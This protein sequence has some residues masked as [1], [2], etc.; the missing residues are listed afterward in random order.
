[1]GKQL[2]RNISYEASL[3]YD[4]TEE[5]LEW[6]F[7]RSN[8]SILY[9]EPKWIKELPKYQRKYIIFLLKEEKK[10]TPELIQKMV[11]TTKL[12]IS[13]EQAKEFLLWHFNKTK[14]KYPCPKKWKK[15]D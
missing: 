15:A 13:E 3:R 6:W 7:N 1:M 4:E 5:L 8:K 11:D 9:E 10:L 12:E 2:I 14:L